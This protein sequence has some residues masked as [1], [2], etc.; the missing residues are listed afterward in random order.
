MLVLSLAAVSFALLASRWITGRRPIT[1]DLATFT[2]VADLADL[3]R[4]I[5]ESETRP[6]TLYLHDPSCPISRR[7]FHNLDSAAR[8]IRVIDVS[9]QHD[10]NRAVEQRTGVRHESPQAFVLFRGRPLWSASHGEIDGDQVD[11]ITTLFAD[12]DPEA[13]SEERREPGERAHPSRSGVR[14]CE[15]PGELLA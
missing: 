8:D 2:P 4:V 3:E 5:A 13:S 6:V 10:L 1:G 14:T 7:A 15:H 9:E 11:R 12:A